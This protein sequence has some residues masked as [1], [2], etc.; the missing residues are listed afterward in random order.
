MSSSP[1]AT[2]SKAA[3]M[4]RIFSAVEGGIASA[5]RIY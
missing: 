4:R 5:N 3:V 1:V 2:D